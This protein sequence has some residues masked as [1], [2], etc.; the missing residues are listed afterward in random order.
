MSSKPFEWD[1]GAALAG[2]RAVAGRD[3]RLATKRIALLVC[4]GIAACRAPMLARSLRK[5]GAEVYV[6]V[7]PSALEFVTSEALA[8]CS[9]NPVTTVLDS[10]AQ[11]V[12]SERVDAYLV[13]PATYSTIG[14]LANGIADNAVTT[15]LASALGHLASGTVA[16]VVA[17]AMHGSMVN[18]VLRRNLATCVG[19]GVTVVPPKGEDD[20][21]KLP[22][23]EV[24]I[25][26][27]TAALTS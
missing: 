27:L 5:S 24:L 11:H 1:L 2:D 19:L 23:D 22:D 12:S 25:A 14:K 26:A 10:R 16:V 6:F 17:P 20:K 15:T 8:W 18:A 13:A 21:A 4:G 3:L 7:T 9:A